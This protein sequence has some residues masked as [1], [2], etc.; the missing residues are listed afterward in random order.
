MCGIVGLHLREP[1][2]YPSLGELLTGM[3]C[4][5]TERGP[6][7]VQPGSQ[8]RGRRQV[9]VGRPV[10]AAQLDPVVV[11]HAQEVGAVVAAVGRRPG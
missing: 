1:S 11:G 9:G 5:V 6:D 3:L 4:Q 7:S 8:R 2:L 10:P